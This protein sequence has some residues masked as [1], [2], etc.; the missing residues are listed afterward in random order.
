MVFG[1]NKKLKDKKFCP[2]CGIQLLSKDSYCTSCRYS[3]VER[4]KKY[5]SSGIKWKSIL[6]FLILILISYIGIQY[7]QSEK[8]IPEIFKKLLGNVS[9]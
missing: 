4:S 3:F 5:K 1:K 6:I 9:S 7:S 8:I 2:G